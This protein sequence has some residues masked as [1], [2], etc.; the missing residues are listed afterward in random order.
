MNFDLKK[1]K[2]YK[3]VIFKKVFQPKMLHWVLLGL[4]WVSGLFL[5]VWFFARGFSID[6]PEIGIVTLSLPISPDIFLGFA[7]LLLPF[8][9]SIFFFELFY[10]FYLQYPEISDSEEN[11]AEH[12]DFAAALL[13]D[14]ALKTA[15]KRGEV[16]LS[17][18]SIL[19]ALTNNPGGLRLI[20]RLGLSP[21]DILNTFKD[22]P[23]SQ[24]EEASGLGVD[25]A[26]L[27][28]DVNSIRQEH[29]NKRITVG[30]IVT[31][32]FDA[33]EAF[34]KMLAGKDL[35]K[36]DL[37]TI[38]LWH[39][40]VRAEFEDRRRFWRLENLLRKRPIGA[41]WVYGYP[42]ML[43]RYSRD[44]TRPFRDGY[45]EISVIGRD[46]EM[47]QLEQSLLRSE[48]QNV[49]LVG[50]AGV[51]KKSLVLGFAQRIAFDEA[52]KALENKKILA[53]NLAAVASATNPAEAQERLTAVMDEATKVGN[54]ILFVEGIHNFVGK[55]EGLGR[56]D[57]SE[58][59]L[60]YL[61]S[62][63]VQVIATTDPMN[64][65][66]FIETRTDIQATF[67]EVDVSELGREAVMYILEDAALQEEAKGG[68]FF[69]YN[70]LSA[71]YEDA[72]RYIQNVPFPEKG[73]T[74]LSD[75]LSYVNAQ[76]KN[77]VEPQDVHEVVTRKTEIPLG[78]IGSEEKEKLSRLEEIMHK[79]IVGQEA[80]VRTVANAMQRLRAGIA[81]EGK[82]AGVF[83]FVGPTGV[84]KTL[85]AKTLAEVYFGSSDK[86][87]RLDMSE[88][89]EQS[90]ISRLLGSLQTDEQGQLASAVRE[91]PFS[92]LL[93]DEFEKAH[94]DLLNVFLR[95]FDE[96]RMTDAFGRE[97]N[98]EN[99]III[100]TSN[101]GAEHIMEMVQ[102]G[103]D[104]S[105]QKERLINLFVEEGYFKPELVNRFDEVVIYHPLNRE[106]IKKV[107]EILIGDLVD[108][109]KEKGYYF[110][111]TPEVINYVADV[112]FDPE[113]G[114]RP[115]NRAIADK[116]ES[117]IAKMILEDKIK[118]GEEFTVPI[119]EISGPVENK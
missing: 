104:P 44:I 83:L 60:P 73:T 108:R 19:V 8:A 86:M 82:P 9:F 33:N 72:R 69:T 4:F 87:V 91:N 17:T 99:N 25:T 85:T 111:P 106:E 81:R 93:L 79:N 38:A 1:A 21:D 116:L 74:L 5:I 90:S 51:G 57:A 92:V 53:L 88:Y 48:K 37:N 97:V 98:F 3:A 58:I 49:L 77:I 41:D 100:A 20:Y 80:A 34:Q 118:K 76:K 56:I 66:K 32:L 62:S 64:F 102:K 46:K 105:S 55:Q 94:R 95:V 16:A 35:L 42:I 31:G 109:L 61:Q 119:S 12:L 22:L 112:G 40:R 6:I 96:G 84:G 65:H 13:F 78:E 110:K 75:V 18:N 63:N 14:E 107:A 89:Q 117:S 113:F 114:A 26:A 23:A 101:A 52:P 29:N 27:L 2:I 39:E 45:A 71:I 7:L 36:K 115:M 70:A 67:E 24:G 30:D 11:L 10:K 59:L 15:K 28:K 50:E 43:S 47:E 103:E 54:V 68:V